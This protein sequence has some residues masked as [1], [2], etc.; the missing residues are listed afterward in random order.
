AIVL[1][2]LFVVILAKLSPEEEACATP[3]MTK[4]ANEKDPEVKKF[5]T[6]CFKL[7]SAGKIEEVTKLVQAYDRSKVLKFLDDYMV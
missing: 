1:S 3:L 6:K 7:F 4:L 2:A 5:A